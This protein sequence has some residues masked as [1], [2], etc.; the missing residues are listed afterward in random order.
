MTFLD[1]G[2]SA[3]EAVEIAIRSLEDKEITNAGFG[4][5][6]TMHGEVECDA[7]I[8]DHFGRSGAVGAMGSKCCP[9]DTL[10]KAYMGLEVRNPIHVARLILEHSTQPL[11]LKRVP[12]NLLVGAGATD[13]AAEKGVPVLP[14][15]AL[16][17]VSANDRYQK[18]RADIERM[19]IKS[20]EDQAK[21]ATSASLFPRYFNENSQKE[22][23]ALKAKLDALPLDDPSYNQLAHCWNESQPYSPRMSPVDPELESKLDN[24]SDADARVLPYNN[25]A[26]GTQ[27]KLAA[28]DLQLQRAQDS[29]SNEIEPKDWHEIRHGDQ[30]N[31]GQA[32]SDNAETDY[33]DE[34]SFVDDDIDQSWLGPAGN[35]HDVSMEDDP[36]MVSELRQRV[37]ADATMADDANSEKLSPSLTSNDNLGHILSNHPIRPKQDAEDDITDTVG[38]IAIDYLGN[39]AAGSSSG[40]IGMK[41]GGRVGPAALVGIG[42]A[43][44]PIDP[45]DADKTCVATVTSGTGEHMATTMAATTCA[46]RLYRSDR[47]SHQGGDEP[48]GDDE[49][50][51]GFVERDFMGKDFNQNRIGQSRKC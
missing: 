34:E 27:L 39:I 21:R 7:T 44:I 29:S 3:V 28:Q 6:L 25:I 47:K 5:N 48:V 38:A 41:H 30:G 16:V 40:G 13:F 46:N 42:S 35:R 23:E 15:D 43:V 22:Q 1:N 50:M 20:Q 10:V 12:P 24:I 9:I 36:M 17:S 11:S 51:K 18:W 45:F 4:S 33:E 26:S 14:P 8:V 32:C 31:D 37:S 2:G 19:Y 49:A